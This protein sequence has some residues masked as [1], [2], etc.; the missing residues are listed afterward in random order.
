MR[1]ATGRPGPLQ[2]DHHP[3]P[4]ASSGG[5]APAL[6]K[7]SADCLRFHLHLA[8]A[9]PGGT[10]DLR[11]SRGPCRDRWGDPGTCPD[12]GG[13][14]AFTHPFTGTQQEGPEVIFRACDLQLGS[15]CQRRA[16]FGSGTLSV[17]FSPETASPMPLPAGLPFSSQAP[18][19][20]EWV[21]GPGWRS[22]REATPGGRPRGGACELDNGS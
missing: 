22:H 15:G 7:A 18:N 8:L 4:A 3:G 5:T 16:N 20:F 11:D 17:V 2:P 21:P 10:A 1:P 12:G 6:R 14:A 13:A 19:P 9:G